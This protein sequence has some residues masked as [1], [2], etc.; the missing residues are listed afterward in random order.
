MQQIGDFLIMVLAS[1]EVMS[2]SMDEGEVMGH[3]TD[4]V[5]VEMFIS[6]D[7]CDESC[8]GM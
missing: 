5:M 2:P 3:L 4:E 6:I 1:N 8:L 7:E